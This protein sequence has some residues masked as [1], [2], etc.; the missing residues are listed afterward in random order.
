M[1]IDYKRLG[2]RTGGWKRRAGVSGRGRGRGREGRGR[3]RER[4][5]VVV[6]LKGKGRGRRPGLPEETA[7]L[8]SCSFFACPTEHS[9]VED[10]CSLCDT[11]TTHRRRRVH[12]SDHNRCRRL[13]R[14]GMQTRRTSG[15]GRGRRLECASR[16]FMSRRCGERLGRCGECRRWRCSSTT[17]PK[18]RR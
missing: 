3:E 1:H 4:N 7:C 18:S 8:A 11:A 9:V 10:V 15:N 12:N 17:T 13:T 2:V 16:T 14:Y 5:G 6:E